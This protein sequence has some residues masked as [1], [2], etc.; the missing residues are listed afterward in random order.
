MEYC[1]VCDANVDSLEYEAEEMVINMI[2]KGHPKWVE[3]DGACHKCLEYY[4]SLENSV[5]FG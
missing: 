4:R 1:K 2:K 3:S 5:K